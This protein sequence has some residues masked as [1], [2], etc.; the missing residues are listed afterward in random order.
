MK[1]RR[2]ALLLALFAPVFAYPAVPT[3]EVPVRLWVKRHGFDPLWGGEAFKVVCDADGDIIITG[4]S[5]DGGGHGSQ[6]TVKYAAADGALLW[7]KHSPGLSAGLA[8]DR[9]DNV[10]VTGSLTTKFLA[11]G[12]VVWTNGGGNA[13]ALDSNGNIAVTGC[14]SGSCYI[15]KYAASDGVLL[16]KFQ[17]NHSTAAMA[18][19]N[20]GNVIVAGN[21]DRDLYTAKY[22]ALDGSLLWGKRYAGPHDNR[23]AAV[24]VDANGSVVVTGH[25]AGDYYTAKY[26][27]SD[28]ALLW[29]RR[30]AGPI[31]RDEPRAV[32]VDSIGNVVVTGLSESYSGAVINLDGYTAKY[33]ALDGAL[34]WEKRYEGYSDDV[35]NGVVV[36]ESDNVVVAGYSSFISCPRGLVCVGIPHRYCV[37]KYA[38]SDG[39]LLWEQLGYLSELLGDARSLALGP[40]GSLAMTGA[41]Y[42]NFATVKYV[43]T[44]ITYPTSVVLSLASS[45][46]GARLR[47]TGDAGRTYRLQRARDPAG[48]WVTFAAVTAPLDGAVEH[49]DSAPLS[50]PAFYRI[51]AP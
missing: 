35:F 31:G 39:T 24:T 14:P 15:A 51:A 3:V 1:I 28:G 16:W 6:S 26:A 29:E 7:E 50:S 45:S 27:A 20:D 2:L 46:E 44:E 17:P 4:N 13:L 33:A 8:V 10:I 34:L 38:A 22:A 21:L 30:Y 42:E 23:A 19:D 12:T 37:A 25:S 32:A 49:L 36:D 47:F 5:F 11:D 18:A 48:P 43:L 40:D 9:N 41:S